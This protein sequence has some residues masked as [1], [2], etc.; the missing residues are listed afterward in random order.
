M[1][2]ILISQIA[3]KPYVVWCDAGNLLGFL[4]LQT[5]ASETFYTLPLPISYSRNSKAALWFPYNQNTVLGPCEVYLDAQTPLPDCSGWPV[6]QSQCEG[7]KQL[8]RGI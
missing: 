1:V 4:G 2:L 6:G 5:Q 8:I 3:Q 7:L